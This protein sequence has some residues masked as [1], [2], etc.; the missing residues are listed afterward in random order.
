MVYLILHL[1][2]SDAYDW[3]LSLTSLPMVKQS[4]VKQ[5][6]IISNR[7]NSSLLRIDPYE[8]SQFGPMKGETSPG[9]TT[10]W[11]VEPAN[12]DPYDSWV[13]WRIKSYGCHVSPVNFVPYNLNFSFTSTNG[14]VTMGQP[15]KGPI[16]T[17]AIRPWSL[18]GKEDEWTISLE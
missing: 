7:S 6:R 10:W 14:K 16:L 2:N 5:G 1:Y 15:K 13:N 3:T 8:Y 4:W 12:F 11:N 18:W 9:Q 17:Y